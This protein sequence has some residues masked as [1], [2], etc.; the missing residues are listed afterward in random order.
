MN[1]F[2]V[3]TVIATMLPPIVKAAPNNEG[4]PR[5]AVTRP[6]FHH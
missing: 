6:S 5:F 2:I 4:G 3:Y 1:I